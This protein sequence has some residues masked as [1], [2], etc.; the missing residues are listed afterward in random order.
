MNYCFDEFEY[1]P[2]EVYQDL[3][4]GIL[5]SKRKN[6][7]RRKSNLWVSYRRRYITP[8]LFKY[9]ER[10]VSVTRSGYK[11]NKLIGQM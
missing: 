9:Y 8:S 5:I 7:I 10:Q 6:S 4:I 1:P 3:V 2:M 11:P